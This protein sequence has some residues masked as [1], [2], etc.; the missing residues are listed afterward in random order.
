MPHPSVNGSL[1]RKNRATDTVVDHDM[2]NTETKCAAPPL[3]SVIIPSWNGESLLRTFLPSVMAQD[4]R[5]FEVIVVDNDSQDQTTAFLRTA[6]PGVRIVSNR[7]NDGTAEGSNIGASEA[8]GR[9]LFFLSNDMLLDP[10]AMRLLVEAMEADPT[11]GI[12]TM[13]MLRITADGQCL[14]SIDSVGSDLDI[15]GFP[16]PR[17]INETDRGQW[18]A[19]ADVFFSFGGA[20]FIRRDLFLSLG[21]YDPAFF[22]LADDI[23]LSWRVRL[24]GFR[25]Q[26]VPGAYLYHRVSATLDTPAFRRARRRFWSERN[27]LRMLIK[28]YS[29]F[30]LL[31]VMPLNLLLLAG[32]TAFWLAMGLPSVAGALFRAMGWNILHIGDTLRHRRRIQ[33]TRVVSDSAIR[34]CMHR[35]SFKIRMFRDYRKRRDDGDWRVFLGRTAPTGTPQ[36]VQGQKPSTKNERPVTTT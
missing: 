18:D 11:L 19:V 36:S 32:E 27:T 21:G 29:A 33:R 23:D 16:G 22:T 25:V 4:Y 34:Q 3:V 28:N 10:S 30:T 15:F 5:P 20:M 17:G 24:L 9:Y 12:C 2:P 14:P 13:K 7:R 31:W 8:S 1:F 6:Y 26:V 35:G